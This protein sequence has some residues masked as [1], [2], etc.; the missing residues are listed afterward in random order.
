MFPAST[1]LCRPSIRKCGTLGIVECI[2]VPETSTSP[3]GGWGNICPG[4]YVLS[5]SKILQSTNRIESAVLAD[6]GLGPLY[7]ES[8]VENG[9]TI[10]IPNWN[11]RPYLP[12]S[13]R[14]ALQA[15]ERLKEAGYSG[16]LLVID[17]ASRDGSQKF[18]RTVQVLYEHAPLKTVFSERNLG[19]PRLRNLAMRMSHY[20]HVCMLD[21]DNELVGSNLPLFLQSGIQTGAAL[22]HGLLIDKREGKMTGLRSDSDES[23]KSWGFRHR[24]EALRLRRLGDDPTSDRSG[25]GRRVRTC[26]D[27]LLSS[28]S[29]IYVCRDSGG[30][31][32][33]P[34]LCCA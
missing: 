2:V 34:T 11:H 29:W 17:D 1:L 21:A 20:R 18:L 13:I 27:G 5:E 32:A 24:P 26:R 14:S 4:R 19:L 28:D 22:V 12:R 6:S 30:Q 16:E 9:V 33:S 23:A 8:K 3:E 7:K 25:R 10:F 15:I 31:G